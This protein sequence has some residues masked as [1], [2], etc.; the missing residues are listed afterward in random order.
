MEEDQE[1]K[2]RRALL[3]WK[4]GPGDMNRLMSGE[5]PCPEKTQRATADSWQNLQQMPEKV[6][7]VK[8]GVPVSAEDMEI[9]RM[10]HIPAV[11]ED[12]WFMYCDDTAIRYYR[13]WTGTLIFEAEYCRDGDGYKITS[14]KVNLE[15]G[16]VPWMGPQAAGS[17]FMCLA[18]ADI[19]ADWYRFWERFVENLEKGE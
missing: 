13:S 19:D 5:N 9:L 18:A 4:L 11:M 14:L 1:L 2:E 3:L 12:H 10:G 7:L 6:G 17:L 15:C 16:D 8:M